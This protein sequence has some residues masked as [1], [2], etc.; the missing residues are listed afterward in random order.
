VEVQM[1]RK[2]LDISARREKVW[3]RTKD[4]LVPLLGELQGFTVLA[5]SWGFC[6]VSRD[7]L[8]L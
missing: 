4:L 1:G 2:P 8:S 7:R 3:R 6:S 5:A